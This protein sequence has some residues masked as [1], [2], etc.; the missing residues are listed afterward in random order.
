MT[1][2]IAKYLENL[3]KKEAKIS[4]F[5]VKV[6][7]GHTDKLSMSV[8]SS[9]QSEYGESYLQDS[10]FIMFFTKSDGWKE[11][12]S[13][14]LFDLVNRGLGKDA[15]GMTESDFKKLTKK[16]TTDI[17]DDDEEGNEEGSEKE[18]TAETSTDASTLFLK[19]TIK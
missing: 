4:H 16:E 17:G 11:G 12:D 3:V 15:N 5:A 1:L 2:D 10:D 6:A 19:I 9:I 7:A 18:E 8:R 13:K 14:K